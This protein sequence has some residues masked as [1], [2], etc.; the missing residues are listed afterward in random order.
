MRPRLPGLTRLRSWAL[1]VKRRFR[2]SSICPSS[3][4][5]VLPRATRS[6][7]KP[8]VLPA[9]VNAPLPLAGAPR[10]LPVRA[11]KAAFRVPRVSKPRPETL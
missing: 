11:L 1:S 8:Q 2:R 6:A 4:R 10:S 7:L 9:W 3:A 5:V